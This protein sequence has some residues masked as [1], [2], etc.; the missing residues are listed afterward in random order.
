MHAFYLDRGQSAEHT[1]FQATYHG[2]APFLVVLLL[3]LVVLL[4]GSH[5]NLVR[6]L[7]ADTGTSQS[8]LE[9]RLEDEDVL[10]LGVVTL[11]LAGNLAHRVAF[12][13]TEHGNECHQVLLHLGRSSQPRPVG[14][15]DL[16]LEVDDGGRCLTRAGAR[17]DA[18]EASSEGGTEGHRLVHLSMAVLLVTEH[19]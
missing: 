12:L 11:E 5:D 8:L 2:L 13:L 15:G 19:V 9:G 10:R 16:C 7:V 6:G 18:F 3:G 4:H 14:V 1:V 17:Q